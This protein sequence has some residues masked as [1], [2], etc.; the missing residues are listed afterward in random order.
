M[1]A[2]IVGGLGSRLAGGDFESGAITAAFARMFNDERHGRHRIDRR[3]F[4]KD[5]ISEW[6]DDKLDMI[7]D[8]VGASAGGRYG[9]G[10]AGDAT[11]SGNVTQ[12]SEGT[13]NVYVGGGEG[14][15]ASYNLTADFRVF[16]VGNIGDSPAF[17]TFRVC[18]GLAIVVRV[19][20]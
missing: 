3:I 15:G 11:I 8:S 9:Y 5:P 13:V 17:S 2:A 20:H 1:T 6:I 16:E 7:K 19:V 10:L 18:G 14:Y 4:A 12:M